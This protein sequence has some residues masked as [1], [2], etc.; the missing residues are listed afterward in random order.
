[1]SLSIVRKQKNNT[2]LLK[3]QHD[4]LAAITYVVRI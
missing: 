4:N 3:N 1:M 2:M